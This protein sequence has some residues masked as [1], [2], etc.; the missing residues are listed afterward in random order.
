MD[1]V[2]AAGQPRMRLREAAA[3]YDHERRR[4]RVRPTFLLLRQERHWSAGR[5]QTDGEQVRL[6]A[7]RDELRQ[8]RVVL[9]SRWGQGS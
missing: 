8:R 5:P 4:A 6:K 2:D 7:V 3:V 9:P 1:R